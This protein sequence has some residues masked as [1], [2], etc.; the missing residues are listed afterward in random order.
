MKGFFGGAMPM[1]L[2]FWNL[3]GALRNLCALCEIF[4][5]GQPLCKFFNHGRYRAH[6]KLKL[7]TVYVLCVKITI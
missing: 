7:H 4:E 2:T 1:C 5:Y 3:C 6:W